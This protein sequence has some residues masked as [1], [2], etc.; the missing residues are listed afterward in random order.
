MSR[1][2]NDGKS[3][4]FT[5]YPYGVNLCNQSTF[6]EA[7][8]VWKKYSNQSPE[9]FLPGTELLQFPFM[10]EFSMG[11]RSRRYRRS[12]QCHRQFLR[13]YC[14]SLS[15][16]AVADAATPIIER[17]AKHRKTLLNIVKHHERLVKHYDTS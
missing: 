14:Q 17:L 11:S 15:Q 6:I 3:T 4:H 5:F 8:F 7:W 10:T 16:S 9:I 2:P 12:L 13:S 1:V